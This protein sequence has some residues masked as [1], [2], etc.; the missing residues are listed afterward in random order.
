MDQK[1]LVERKQR[2]KESNLLDQRFNLALAVS[3]SGFWDWDMVNNQL[4][5]S[6][7][8]KE[9]LGYKMDEIEFTMEDFWAM[10]HPDDVPLVQKTLENHLKK[11]EKYNIEFRLASKSGEFLWF[12]SVGQAVWT[13]SNEAIR[14]AGSITD[15]TQRKKTEKEFEQFKELY[16]LVLEGSVA[17]IW[18]Y[19]L[20][21]DKSYYSDRF[22]EL[23]GY[24]P[25]ELANLTIEEALSHIHPDFHEKVPMALKD[26]LEGKKP[27]Y[28]IDYKVRMKTGEYRWFHARGKASWDDNGQ[29]IRVAGSFVDIHEQKLAH[30]KLIKSERYFRHLME[31]SPLAI[32]IFMPDGKISQVN[33]SWKKL[34]G[35]NEEETTQV[36]LNY[37]L[38]TDKQLEDLGFKPLVE[39]AFKGESIILSPI[40]YVGNTTTAHIGLQDVE[41][42]TRMI[43]IHIY[44][45]KDT[46]GEVEYVVCINMDLTELKKAERT[47]DIQRESL[48]RIDRTSIMGQLTGSIA[49]ELN[50]PLTGI[51]ANSQAAEIMLQS[52]T[53][54]SKELS[55]IMRDIVADT[56]RA[57]AV[58]RNLREL[59][60]DQKAVFNDININSII[61]E[62]LILLR[63]EL[64]KQNVKLKKILAVDMPLIRGNKV[65]IQQVF[66]NLMM[67][68]IE[69]MSNMNIKQSEI[70]ITTGYKEGK[71]DLHIDDIGPGIDE[72]KI[73]SIFLPL[74]TWKSG[75]TG[76]GLAISNSIIESHGGMMYAENLSGEGARVGFTI[77][78]IAK[79][80][81]YE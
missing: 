27:Y 51:L 25:K 64:L 80:Y 60:K 81:S 34:W 9:L 54:E 46:T 5:T 35:F 6:P 58:I 36:M 70:T 67:N 43:Q 23:I 16:E 77:P 65:Q 78:I 57:G 18:D 74:A 37:N 53:F 41:A 7:R 11:K 40:E 24:D 42:Q 44:P 66:V 32:A 3:I 14:M 48:A 12:H 75:G 2:T 69:A 76:M 15:I 4:Y 55:E 56:K 8:L 68:A 38:H 29:P 71:V 19:N 50:Q 33:A 73:D 30:E 47:A 79:I 21:A 39:R 61:E 28:S 59:Y 45:V 52:E 49:H 62:T 13:K 20:I 31:A 26:H 1:N 63:S 10:L 22:K 72:D 17:G